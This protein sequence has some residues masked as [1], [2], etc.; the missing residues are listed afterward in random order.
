[1]IS[2]T[3]FIIH[4]A[5]VVSFVITTVNWEFNYRLANE[6]KQAL[7]DHQVGYYDQTTGTFTI[8]DK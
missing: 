6:Y 4:A 1:M 8:K 5:I 3:K 7:I 2:N